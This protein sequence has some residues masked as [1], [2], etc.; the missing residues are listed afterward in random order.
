MPPWTSTGRSAAAAR[1]REGEQDEGED[2]EQPGQRQ[3][4]RARSVCGAHGVNSSS[5]TNERMAAGRDGLP[6]RGDRGRSRAA[7]TR[8]VGE[9]PAPVDV[10]Q[11]LVGR[12]RER[13]LLD[14]YAARLADGPSGFVLRGESGIGKT[15]LWRAGVLARCG[16]TAGRSW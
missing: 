9:P 13:A 6:G 8:R 5:D 10:F 4:D 3:A 14:G 12:D 1:A 15:A 7:Y 16:P 2:G 11:P